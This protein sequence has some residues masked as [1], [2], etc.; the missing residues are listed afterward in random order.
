[1][2]FI[3][4]FLLFF[5][6]S[7]IMIKNAF[8]ENAGL[9]RDFPGA[10][11]SVG[12]SHTEIKCCIFSRIRYNESTVAAYFRRVTA[13]QTKWEDKYVTGSSYQKQ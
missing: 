13:L 4:F 11:I 6:I 1:M 12:S 3:D 2:D 7:A 5:R 8:R 9:S 10:F